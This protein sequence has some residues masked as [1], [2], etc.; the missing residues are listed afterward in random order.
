MIGNLCQ[1]STTLGL[2]PVARSSATQTKKLHQD[3]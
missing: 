3:M 1:F 2:D